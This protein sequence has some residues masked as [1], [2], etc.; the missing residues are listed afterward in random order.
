MQHRQLARVDR[1]LAEEAEGARELG[2][3]AEAVLVVEARV[4]AVDRRLEVRRRARPR[5]GVSVRAALADRRRPRRSRRR[6]TPPIDRWRTPGT[7]AISCAASRPRALSM[8]QISGVTSGPR[9]RRPTARP[10]RTRPSAAGCPRRAVPRRR[11]RGGR[12]RCPAALMR[13]HAGRLGERA[14]RPSRRACALASAARRPRGRASPRRRRRRR[15]CRA[16]CVVA[17]REQVAAVHQ[18]TPP[19]VAPRAAAASSPS[20]SA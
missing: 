19:R 18:I 10:R 7:D 5:R 17:G 6:S 9:D 12:A 11:G 16:A 3:G 14:A 2:L 8:A 4:D 1:R 13:T 15:P 20:C